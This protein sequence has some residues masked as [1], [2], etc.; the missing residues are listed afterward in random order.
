MVSREAVSGRPHHPFPLY[1]FPTIRFPFI[2]WAFRIALS[3]WCWPPSHILSTLIPSSVSIFPTVSMALSDLSIPSISISFALPDDPPVEPFS[4]F[5]LQPPS[6]P[7]Q[8]DG[9][10]P[11]LLSPP[12]VVSPRFCRQPS[13]LRPPD[14][15]PV[16]KGLDRGRFEALLASTRERNANAKKEPDLRKE[17]A[18]KAHKSKQSTLLFFFFFSGFDPCIESLLV[19]RRA[20]FLSKVHAPPSPTATGLP[21]T[22]PES[23]AIFHYSLP[24][25]GLDSPLTVFESLQ[26]TDP[27]GPVQHP[28]VQPWVEQVQYR[29]PKSASARLPSLEQITAHLSSHGHPATARDEYHRPPIP[30]PTFLR[31]PS[32]TKPARS[33]SPPLLPSEE[34]DG[35]RNLSLKSRHR[36]QRKENIIYPSSRLT[37]CQ[38]PLA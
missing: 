26:Q 17:L 7:T 31:S 4:P 12:P 3:H 5:D 1:S 21:T 35:Q 15:L 8:E 25:P 20:L 6:P 19:E 13:P 16:A 11:S 36:F 23:P 38:C 28:S 32:R 27:S 18:M 37:S 34:T 30:L 22:P 2:P 14:T 33:T 9:Y 29:Q 24:S 10:R